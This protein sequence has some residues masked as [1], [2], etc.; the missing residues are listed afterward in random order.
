[1]FSKNFFFAL[2]TVMLIAIAAF[3]FYGLQN[4][5]HIIKQTIEQNGSQT[6][7]TAVTL[8]KVD[9][10]LRSGEGQ[11]H[12]L[13]INNPEGFS[14]PYAFLMEKIA[15]QIAPETVLENVVVIKHIKIDGARLVAEQKNLKD[16]NLYELAKNVKSAKS[17]ESA[18]NATSPA[19]KE[20]PKTALKVRLMIEK[21]I[22]SNISL[23]LVTEHFGNKTLTLPTI[24]LT[25][26]GDKQNGLAPDELGKAIM[27]PLM[28]KVIKAAK[29]QIKRL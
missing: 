4:L 5:D 14:T 21:I 8:D 26:I 24:E 2:V 23:Q 19:D 13:Q 28:A 15:I 10:S 1:M 12:R 18:P 7:Q 3:A 20:A 6:T 11:L 9:L 17:A 27:K 25:N 29:G 22:L 16:L